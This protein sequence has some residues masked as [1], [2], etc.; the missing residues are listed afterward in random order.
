MGCG[1]AKKAKKAT[2]KVEKPVVKKSTVAK[3]APKKS[4]VVS[5]NTLRKVIIKK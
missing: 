3:S 1:C 4:S 2:K 5:I